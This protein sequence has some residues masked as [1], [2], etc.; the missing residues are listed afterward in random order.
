MQSKKIEFYQFPLVIRACWLIGLSSPA[1][2]K[3]FP[4]YRRLFT[5]R[6]DIS[7]HLSRPC[8]YSEYLQS[9]PIHVVITKLLNIQ[10][11]E[12]QSLSRSLTKFC[13]ECKQFA[14]L[15]VCYPGH[16]YSGYFRSDVFSSVM[17]LHSKVLTH[18]DLSEC[19]L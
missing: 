11:P 5:G 15:P 9:L 14:V 2:G 1:P 3:T 12:L 16:D 10:F 6:C 17:L 19:T 18:A 7:C 13:I 4:E 8:A